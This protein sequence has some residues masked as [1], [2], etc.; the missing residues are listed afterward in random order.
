MPT[1]TP[2]ITTPIV[3]PEVAPRPEKITFEQALEIIEN[4]PE[5]RTR[6]RFHLGGAYRALGVLGRRFGLSDDE[7]TEGIQ[8][9]YSELADRLR[10]LTGLSR[11]DTYALMAANDSLGS[12]NDWKRVAELAAYTRQKLSVVLALS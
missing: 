10:A 3:T 9:N 4:A 6:G 12:S 5:R 8:H 11:N 1:L 7:M 2:E